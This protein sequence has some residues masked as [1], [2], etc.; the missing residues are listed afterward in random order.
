MSSE[1]GSLPDAEDRRKVFTGAGIAGIGGSLAFLTM[2]ALSFWP[3][4][5]AKTE[6]EM[7]WLLMGALT[8]LYGTGTNYLRKWV[9]N[10][11][12]PIKSNQPPEKP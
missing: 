8:T 4:F 11:Q 12:V 1:A 10:T 2:F 3:A 7:G 9:T 5:D 6:G